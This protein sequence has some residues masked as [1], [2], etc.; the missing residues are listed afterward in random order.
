MASFSLPTRHRLLS[1]RRER[2][3]IRRA[4][5]GDRASLDLLVAHNLRLLYKIAN[6]YLGS[7]G[8]LEIDDLVH[9]GVMGLM[10]AVEKFDFR[11]KTRFSTYAIWWV[12]QSI[13]RAIAAAS[14]TIRLPVHAHAL[15]RAIA[16]A[17]TTLH[18]QL[19]RPPD[20]HD[21]ADALDLDPATVAA[22]QRADR[23]P[24]SLNTPMLDDSDT[25]ASELIPDPGSFVDSEAEEHELARIVA[26]LLDHL[27]PRDRRVIELALGF[28]G[29]QRDFTSIADELG[30]SPERVRQIFKRAVE[31]IR[32]LAVR[33]LAAYGYSLPHTTSPNGD[34]PH[35]DTSGT[36]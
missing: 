9:E 13:T 19:G 7:A 31:K 30:L 22:V 2:A 32:P 15:S 17:S 33:R 18:A 28:H 36:A 6:E 3:L 5:K 16:A 25:Q 27:P 23:S 26:Q 21:I 8:G 35:A 29:P 1:A 11:E 4:Q 24:L 20:I 12:R 14:R 34:A 10:H